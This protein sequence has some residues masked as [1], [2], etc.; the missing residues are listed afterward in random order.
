MCYVR[1]GSDCLGVPYRM[2]LDGMVFVVNLICFLLFPILTRNETVYHSSQDLL[3]VLPED[4]LHESL[5]SGQTPP[6]A[7]YHQY[8][9]V[10]T[11]T[12]TVPQTHALVPLPYLVRDFSFGLKTDVKPRK[13]IRGRQL[14]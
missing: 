3:Q 8:C 14:R 1:S 13:L 10:G 11:G 4:P 5:L 9:Q 12:G 2:H 6:S 7:G